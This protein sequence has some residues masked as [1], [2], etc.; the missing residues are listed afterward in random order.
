M[1]TWDNKAKHFCYQSLF[2]TPSNVL[3]L[4]LKQ[5]FPPIIWIF[6]EDEGDG[7]DSRLPFKIFSTLILMYLP[8]EL[9]KTYLRIQA[10][11]KEK[12]RGQSKGSLNYSK[13]G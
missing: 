5:T 8:Q 1:F 10:E 11:R 12:N 13:T 2:T 6:T 9:L 7:I 4:H 3:P